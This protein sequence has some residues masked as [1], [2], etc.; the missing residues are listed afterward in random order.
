MPNRRTSVSHAVVRF[1]NRLGFLAALSL[2]VAIPAVFAGFTIRG[3]QRALEIETSQVARS[4]EQIVIQRPDLWTYEFLRLQELIDKPVVGGMPE[5]R[6]VRTSQG[7]E[8]AHSTFRAPWPTLRCTLPFHD[9]GRVV[10]FLEARR[11]IR[12]DLIQTLVVALGS[13]LL[14]WGLFLTFQLLPVQALGRA[15]AE[16]SDER[17][18][19]A[20][21]LRA[22]PDGIIAADGDGNVAFL[23]LAAEWLLGVEAQAAVGQPLS[24]VYPVQ[25]PDSPGTHEGQAEL[26]RPGQPVRTFEE[27]HSPLPGEWGDQP[28]QVIVFR[29]ITSQL[30]TEAELLRVRQIESLGVLAG[31]IAHD[32]NNYLSAILGNISLARQDLPAGRAADRLNEAIKATDRARSLSLKLLTFAKGG[33][34]ARRVVDLAPLVREAAEFATHGTGVSFSCEVQPGLWNAEVDDGLVSQVVHNLVINA[35]QAMQNQGRLRIRVENLQVEGS[36][37]PHLRP[38]RYLRVALQDSG[39]GISPAILPRIFEPYFTTKSAGNGLGLASCFNIMR[40]HGGSIS[41]ES[42]LGQG[43]TFVLHLPATEKALDLRPAAPTP[44]EPSPGRGR[45]LVMEDDAVLVEIAAEML[46]RSGFTA[47]TCPTGEMALE[48]YSRALQT[49]SPFAAVIMDLTIAGGMGGRETAAHILALHPEAR[50][51]VSSGYSVDPVMA[52][53][54][55]FGFKAILPKPY[56]LAD[57]A[58]VMDDVLPTGG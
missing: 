13:A 48:A 58:R 54:Q 53:P 15:L 46:E 49:G 42:E 33:D 27:R 11:S 56:S 19:T 44:E 5:D 34:P 25:R 40:A 41:A 32:F 36:E 55:D 10:G 2:T 26:H 6:A 1:L 47:Q 18:R 20:A 12:R 14:G 35:V 3:A 39:P 23:N 7:V 37:L 8:L 45:V 16:L 29:E 38:G 22:I 57:L 4:L 24:Q 43:A 17:R 30:R 52:R 50:L 31:G 9:S 28:G 51:I 21:T